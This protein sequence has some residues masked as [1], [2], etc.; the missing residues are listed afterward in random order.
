MAAARPATMVRVGEALYTTED[1][2]ASWHKSAALHGKRGQ[3]ALS[4]DGRILLHSPEGQMGS[5]RSLDLGASWTPVRGLNHADMRAVA[6]PLDPAVFYAYDDGYGD[7]DGNRNGNLLASVD[8]GASFVRRSRL[9]AGASTL[10]RLA[11]C[12]AGE[13]WVAL[14]DGGLAR[15]QDGGLHFRRLANVG[16]CAALGFGKPAS[17]GHYPALY[18]WGTVGGVRGVH[19]SNDAGASWLRVNDDAHQYGG[20]GDDQFVVGDMNTYGVVYMSTA[21]RGIVYGKPAAPLGS[22]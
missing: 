16:Y 5:Y 8:G 15:S 9:P 7:G 21:G 4:A 14:K 19:R 1:A 3:V 18:I 10:I 12:R 22:E 6:D 17:S 11:P 20:P 13:L 2:G